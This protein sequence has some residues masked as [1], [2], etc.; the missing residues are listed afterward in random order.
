MHYPKT[1][2]GPFVASLCSHQ[3][4]LT[5]RTPVVFDKEG[6]PLRFRF[7]GK[8]SC[9]GVGDRILI[10]CAD[11]GSYVSEHRLLQLIAIDKGK[12]STFD[13]PAP[14]MLMHGWGEA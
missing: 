14:S 5:R 2:H 10:W 7:R 1:V 13:L 3:Q 11:C 9:N 8:G 12:N 6:F 4:E